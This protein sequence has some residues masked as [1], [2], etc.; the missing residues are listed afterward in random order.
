MENQNAIEQFNEEK[1]RE[2]KVLD[3]LSENE[4]L[5]YMCDTAK[6]YTRQYVGMLIAIAT[7]MVIS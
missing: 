1:K 4:Q 6:T 7:H 5:A 3:D 2:A